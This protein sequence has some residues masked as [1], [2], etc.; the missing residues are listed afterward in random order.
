MKASL[1]RIGN[2]QGVRLPRAMIAQAGLGPKL[3]IEVADGAIVIR[4]AKAVRE[5]WADDAKACGHL[6][7]VAAEWDAPVAD[8]EGEW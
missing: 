8:F 4:P 1:I 7:Q 5:G 2:S 6:D 3:E